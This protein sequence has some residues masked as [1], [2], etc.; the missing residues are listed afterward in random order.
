MG[1]AGGPTHLSLHTRAGVL[2]QQARG[3]ERGLPGEMEDSFLESLQAEPG[4][5]SRQGTMALP[6][7]ANENLG[8]TS[9][10]HS[11]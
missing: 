7:L 5:R 11:Q 9:A 1:K 6:L 10:G 8:K 2:P 3:H 4:D